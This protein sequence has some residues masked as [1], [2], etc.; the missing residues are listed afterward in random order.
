VNS[1]HEKTLVEIF[2]KPVPR[3]MEL[4]RIEALFIAL[5]AE[6]VEGNGSRVRFVLN[7]VIATFHR[8]HPA[9]EA[10]LYQVIDARLFLEQAGVSN[11]HND[12]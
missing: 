5:G 10:K 9:K 12:L 2:T 4:R 8:P 1:R 3:S 6:V 7:G 11:E